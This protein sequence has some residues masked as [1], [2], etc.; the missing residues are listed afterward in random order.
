M[1]RITLDSNVWRIVV[2]PEKFPNEG[3]L[4]QFKRINEAIYVLIKSLHVYRRPYLR[5]RRSG[6][7]T[8]G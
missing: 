3:S 6:K 1:L 5:L 8:W 2:S 7:D 4:T